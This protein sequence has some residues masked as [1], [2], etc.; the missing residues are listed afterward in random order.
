MFNFTFFFS[1]TCTA[2]NVTAV[3]TGLQNVTRGKQT[4]HTCSL[5]N[6]SARSSCSCVMSSSKLQ[7]CRKPRNST[8]QS[9]EKSAH[10]ARKTITK[11]LHFLFTFRE[12]KLALNLAAR[13]HEFE[14]FYG[15]IFVVSGSLNA[16]IKQSNQQPIVHQFAVILIRRCL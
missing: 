4:Q 6:E 7:N 16:M 3:W 14:H 9:H 11:L 8:G 2:S 5:E 1:N 10:V 12:C 15:F 13:V